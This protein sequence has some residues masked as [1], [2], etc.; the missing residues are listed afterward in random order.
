MKAKQLRRLG[1]IP[2]NVFGKSLPDPISIQLKENDARKLI[3]QK[4]EGSKLTLDV[5]GTRL[6]VQIKEKAIDSIKGEIQHISFQTLTADEKV[7]SVIH[8]LLANDD[9]VSGQLEKMLMEIPYA[10]L[11]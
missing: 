8:I 3:R 5:D 11:P 10:S 4:H 2:A 6:L 7:N 9:K 1:F